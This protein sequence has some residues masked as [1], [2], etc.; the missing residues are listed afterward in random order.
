MSHRHRRCCLRCLKGPN[1][2]PRI[3]VGNS[4]RPG[5]QLDP[6]LTDNRV[7]VWGL[8]YQTI[9]RAIN[10]R[11]LLI[12]FD[13]EAR[14]NRHP[15]QCRNC[16]S[17][18]RQLLTFPRKSMDT[19]FSFSRDFFVFVNVLLTPRFSVEVSLCN[20]TLSSARCVKLFTY[21]C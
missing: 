13:L 14:N 10:S 17:L 16:V 3:R 12:G 15:N 4:W 5:G 11:W 2:R 1:T 21:S 20:E 8:F 19:D 7:R 6:F 9:G 18:R